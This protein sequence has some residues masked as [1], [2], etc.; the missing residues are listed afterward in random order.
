MSGLLGIYICVSPLSAP[1]GR[2]MPT[3]APTRQLLPP[4]P[5][6]RCPPTQPPQYRTGNYVN[7]SVCVCVWPLTEVCVDLTSLKCRLFVL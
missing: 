3:S 7:I 6:P 2:T 1:H 4:S 5:P